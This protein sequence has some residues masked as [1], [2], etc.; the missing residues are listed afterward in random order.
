MTCVTKEEMVYDEK[1]KWLKMKSTCDDKINTLSNA[2]K[3][4]SQ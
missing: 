4:K 2:L 1:Q 3:I